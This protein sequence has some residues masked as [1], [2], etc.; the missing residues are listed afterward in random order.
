MLSIE[1][2]GSIIHKN[3][4]IEDDLN[5]RIRVGLMKWRNA[6]GVLC[7]HKISIRLKGNFLKDYYKI[8]YDIWYLKN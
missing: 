4:K 7:D 3:G 5:S 8:R 2:L 1:H 6:K